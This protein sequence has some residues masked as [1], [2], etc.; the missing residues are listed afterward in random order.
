MPILTTYTG[1]ELMRE[2]QSKVCYMIL[3]LLLLGIFIRP[4]KISSPNRY[5]FEI[6]VAILNKTL[7]TTQ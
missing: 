5:Y 7:M 2:S 3:P 1:S 6:Q 4:I